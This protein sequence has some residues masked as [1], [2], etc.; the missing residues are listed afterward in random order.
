MVNY[1][2]CDIKVY[3]DY[4]NEGSYKTLPQNQ[5]C[6]CNMCKIHWLAV[7]IDQTPLWTLNTPYFS[8][9]QDK[10]THTHTPLFPIASFTHNTSHFSQLQENN[11]THTHGCLPKFHT[12]Y[13]SFIQIT[14]KNHMHIVAF[15][16][17]KFHIHLFP[18]TYHSCK[19]HTQHT[20]L[21]QITRKQSHICT[22]IFGYLP[23]FQI[24]HTTHLCFSLVQITRQQLILHHTHTHTHTHTFNLEV[25]FRLLQIS[26]TTHFWHPPNYF[27]KITT[28]FLLS[29][30]MHNKVKD[31]NLEL[32]C[33]K[34]LIWMSQKMDTINIVRDLYIGVCN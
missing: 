29:L 27:F 3:L 12:Q 6:L 7:E 23:L 21:F 16:S 28:I 17:C 34:G 13:I 26:Y 4:E 32:L 31:N 14:R 33:L 19:F 18:P 20:S 30:I 2:L 22:P 11:H 8:K 1:K 24:P 5:Q 9:S 25:A 15:H 10:D